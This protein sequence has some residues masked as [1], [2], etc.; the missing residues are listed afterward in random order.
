MAIVRPVRPIQRGKFHSVE[1]LLSSA[2]M[3]A[4]MRGKTLALS[5]GDTLTVN[6]TP[7]GWIGG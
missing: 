3:D 6:R 1:A 5:F 7:A 2:V 4:T